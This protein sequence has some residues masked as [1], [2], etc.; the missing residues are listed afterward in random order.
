MDKQLLGTI[1]EGLAVNEDWKKEIHSVWDNGGKTADQYTV[2]MKDGDALGLSDNPTHPQGF[3]QW[4]SGV[5]AGSH[6]GKKI[7]FDK[8]PPKVKKHVE[9][10]L[11]EAY[12]SVKMNEGGKEIEWSFGLE[13]VFDHELKLFEQDVREGARRLTGK[14][15]GNQFNMI[16]DNLINNGGLHDL[17]EQKNIDERNAVYTYVLMR[18]MLYFRGK[19]K[20]DANVESILSKADKANPPKVKM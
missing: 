20:Y 5:R 9:D 1:I 19:S 6:L 11:K 7:S 3:S 13:D 17:L 4:D 10:R 14:A 8:L 2:V 16:L 15:L 12:E 18:M